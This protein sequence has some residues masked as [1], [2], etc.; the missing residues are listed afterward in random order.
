MP[1]HNDYP[2]PRL[3]WLYGAWQIIWRWNYKQFTVT[4]EFR[5]Q[6]EDRKFADILLRQFAAALAE[7]NPE[8][9]FPERYEDAAGVRR[10]LDVRNLSAIT[11]EEL[12]GDWL[13]AYQRTLKGSITKGW[14][15]HTNRY[16]D[17]LAKFAGD[18]KKVSPNAAQE[19]LNAVLA[20]E[21]GG[22]S[23][24]ARPKSAATHNK[25]LSAC[26]KFYEW[27]IRTR[28]C[29]KN[30]FEGIKR[31]REDENSNIVYCTKPQRREII[32]LAK[33]SGWP[34][35]MAVPIA[36]Y[37]GMRREE[38]ARMAWRDIRFAEGII[39]IKKT[40]TGKGRETPLHKHLELMLRQTPESERGGYVVKMPEDTG[41]IEQDLTIRADR[42][43]NFIHRLRDDRE[44]Q[45]L[46]LWGLE[47]PDLF[48][49][50]EPRTM[51]GAEWAE[52]KR[53]YQ[54]QMREWRAAKKVR[55][56]DLA[57]DMERIGWNSFRHTFASL[58]VQSG[59]EIDTVTS[60]MGNTPAVCWR[61]YAQFI[62]RDRRDD[63]IDMI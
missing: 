42:L 31:L 25:T 33:D 51:T 47:K 38:I 34:D 45:L 41:D 26:S 35:W 40:K 39:V 29:R 57:A 32:K 10:Y 60:W 18:L 17:R 23:G 44:K 22:K 11:Q 28:R 37:S 20:G 48:E 15:K 24:R 8:G 6:K 9:M 43:T 36:F 12:E 55:S 54:K 58:A 62:P 4:T 63:R 50:V 1:P 52:K 16:L 59:I 3:R 14:G 49:G 61:H 2:S 56:G 19:Y 13:E 53:K 30:P 21:D 5:R 7:D 27:A 46:K